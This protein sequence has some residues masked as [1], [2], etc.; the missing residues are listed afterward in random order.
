[1]PKWGMVI[2]LN[3][4]TGC[5]ACVTACRMENN[6]TNVGA[7]PA[8]NG[9]VMNWMEIITE[10]EGEFPDV[11]VTHIPRPCF[12]CE[13]A[14]CTVVCPVHATFKNEDGLIGQIYYRCI[15][16]RYCMNACPYTAKCFNFNRPETPEAFEPLKNPD[17]T[18][19]MVGVVE[20]CSFCHHRLAMAKD[21]ARFEDR[22]LVENDY[23]TACVES[24]PADAITFGDLDN[25][26]HRVY[27]QKNSNRAFRLEESLGTEPK[28]YYLKK[29][30]K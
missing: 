4:C 16:C 12:Q 9:R 8:Q 15:G 13:N 24:C 21:I 19:R 14:P 17:V 30:D 25:A 18:E 2:D 23:Q 5:S 20:K 1:M 27:E 28:V 10:Y 26:E 22:E 11:R 6:I 29:E 7:E 3:K